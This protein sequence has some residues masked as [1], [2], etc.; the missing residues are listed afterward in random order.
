MD[1]I[2]SVVMAIFIIALSAWHIFGRKPKK[3]MVW[4]FG[5]NQKRT[6]TRQGRTR[7]N[8]WRKAKKARWSLKKKKKK[9]PIPTHKNFSHAIKGHSQPIISFSISPNKKWIA[10]SSTDQSVRITELEDTVNSSAKRVPL[11]FRINM[12]GDT[13]TSLSWAADC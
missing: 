10:T 5:K 1:T 3:K 6:K 12:N 7:K 9:D 4:A 13:I 11:F 2:L 8:E